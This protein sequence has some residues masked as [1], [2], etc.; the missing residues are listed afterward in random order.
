M[1]GF[2][3]WSVRAVCFA[4]AQMFFAST[5]IRAILNLNGPHYLCVVRTMGLGLAGLSDGTILC[6][7]LLPLTAA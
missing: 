7:P 3:R 4:G 2:N 1:G 5:Q 6:A